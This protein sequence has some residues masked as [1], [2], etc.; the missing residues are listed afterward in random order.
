VQGT[1]GFS[2]F[3]QGSQGGGAGKNAEKIAGFDTPE[4]SSTS[5]A[6]S[7]I[8]LGRTTRTCEPAEKRRK[9][10]SKSKGLHILEERKTVHNSSRSK[11]S[12]E[13]NPSVGGG[14]K[15][16]KLGGYHQGTIARSTLEPKALHHQEVRGKCLDWNAQ[17]K[18][19]SRKKGVPRLP[20]HSLEKTERRGGRPEKAKL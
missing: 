10:T 20:S 12:R 6:R 15:R 18:G 4:G 14:G 5:L 17:K 16:E 7:Q 19:Q 11:G 1:R 2:A 3:T 9:K 8:T 13:P